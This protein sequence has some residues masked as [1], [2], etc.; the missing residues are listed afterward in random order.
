MGVM[1]LQK[2]LELAYRAGMD[3]VEI[4]PDTNPPVCAIMDFG[5]FK[6]EEK[7]KKRDQQAKTKAAA[8][9]EVRLRPVSEE[10][11]ILTKIG[12]LKKFLQDKHPVGVNMLFKEREMRHRERGFQVMQQII[13]S[14][15]DVGQVV[16][17]P[18]FE[19][20]RL[21]LRLVPKVQ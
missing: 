14:L 20:T 19:G 2:A 12:Q 3:L 11:D 17:P 9:K 4:V 7:R 21:S 6:F 5:K 10:H 16:R 15:N 1:P 18:R 13:D 8:I